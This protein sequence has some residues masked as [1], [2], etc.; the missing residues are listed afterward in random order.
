MTVRMKALTSLTYGTRRLKAG[1]E[2][3]A[4][5]RGHVMLLS[6][7]GKAA[8]SDTGKMG[9]QGVRVIK[10]NPAD[11]AFPAAPEIKSISENDASDELRGLRKTYFTTTG[12]KAYLGWDETQLRQRI[13]D[14]KPTKDE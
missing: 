3:D 4:A 2:F 7:I 12:R 11:K 13:A 9:P 14:L 8:E 10:P 6:K 1:D 5:N